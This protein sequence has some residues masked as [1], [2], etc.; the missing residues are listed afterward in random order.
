MG[1]IPEVILGSRLINSG[2]SC[3]CWMA[4]TSVVSA[5]ANLL[6]D[7][8]GANYTRRGAQEVSS[9]CAHS[10]LSADMACPNLKRD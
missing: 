4:S 6:A 10:Y 8:R 7:K 2:T 5:K 1:T 3:C 9:V